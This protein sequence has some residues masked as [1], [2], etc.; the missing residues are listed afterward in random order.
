MMIWRRRDR[1]DQSADWQQPQQW[2]GRPRLWPVLLIVLAVVLLGAL[3]WLSYRQGW[4]SFWR[5]SPQIIAAFPGSAARARDGDARGSGD[6]DARGDARV[7]GVTRGG[8]AKPDGSAFQAERSLLAP[9]LSAFGRRLI[10]DGRPRA[11]YRQAGALGIPPAEVS[12]DQLPADD[13]V[14]LGGFYVEQGRRGDFN[15]WWAYFRQDYG[16][17]D[18]YARSAAGEPGRFD[19]DRQSWRV[20]LALARVLAESLARWP[21]S[22]RDRELRQLSAYLL[23]RW[24]D[25]LPSEESWLAPLPAGVPDLE[26]TPTPRPTGPSPAPVGERLGAIRPATLDLYALELLSQIDSAWQPRAETARRAVL[27][28][29]LDADTLPLFASVYYPELS[30]YRT[31]AD[32]DQLL[33]S[34]EQALTALRLAEVGSLPAETLNWIRAQMYKSTPFGASISLI[35][36]VPQGDRDSVKAL[37][38]FARIAR[39]SGDDALY[40]QISRRL[41]SHRASSSTSAVRHLIYGIDEQGSVRATAAENIWALLALF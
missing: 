11:W 38:C 37:A 17:D 6:G 10:V 30:A 16:T 7:G 22:S 1:T 20:N 34:D 4:F 19:A 24:Q 41:L 21:D 8:M 33:P 14:R 12:A 40:A 3:A 23:S 29:L 36:Q 25:P 15:A 5:P 32:E 9:A 27:G 13:A 26:A 2:A 18:G 28:S 35:D 31:D 39:L